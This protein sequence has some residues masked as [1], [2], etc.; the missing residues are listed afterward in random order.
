MKVSFSIPA[1]NEEAVIGKCLEAVLAEIS[2]SGIDAEIVVVNNASTDRT[3]EVASSYPGV[4]VIDECTKGLTHARAAGMR[5]TTGEIIANVDAD[6]ILL[7]GWLTTVVT[8]FKDNPKRVALSGPFIYYDLTLFEQQLT[9][10]FYW[11]G[12]G[13]HLFNHHILRTGAMLQGGNFVIR[14]DAFE[15]V[16]GFDTSIAFYGEDTDVACRLAKVGT[17]TWTWDLPV[18]SSG[19]RLRAEGIVT[20]GWRYTLNHLSIIFFHRPATQLYSDI[21]ERFVREGQPT[22]RGEAIRSFRRRLALPRFLYLFARISRAFD[23]QK[24]SRQRG[25][26]Q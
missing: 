5:A 16:G 23:V 9:R 20:M 21:R 25:R 10:F 15:R 11:I 26:S 12:Y 17:V 7:P 18:H 13:L 8:Y 2:R 4:R 14:R 24:G 6:V 19:R 3:R 22:G 1:Y